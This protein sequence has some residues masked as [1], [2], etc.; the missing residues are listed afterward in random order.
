[1]T[2]TTVTSTSLVL[3]RVG[4]VSWRLNAEI[5]LAIEM[6]WIVGSRFWGHTQKGRG[7]ADVL[8]LVSGRGVAS[9]DEQLTRFS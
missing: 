2:P 4:L 6:P 3:E 1:M 8:S 5:V 7:G 9:S